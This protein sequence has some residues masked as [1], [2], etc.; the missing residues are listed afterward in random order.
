MMEIDMGCLAVLV[1]AVNTHSCI[2]VGDNHTVTNLYF[3]ATRAELQTEIGTVGYQAVTDDYITCNPAVRMENLVLDLRRSSIF[4]TSC[5]KRSRGAPETLVIR[6]S[7]FVE[8][9]QPHIQHDTVNYQVT[10][11]HF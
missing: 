2:T 3:A 10:F 5:F 6:N 8:I 11:R 4:H 9:L 7:G 1:T